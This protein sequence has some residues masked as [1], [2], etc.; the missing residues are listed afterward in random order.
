LAT[1]ARRGTGE[2]RRQFRHRSDGE[3]ANL[4]KRIR[5]SAAS[6][7]IAIRER[8]HQGFDRGSRARAEA[9]DGPEQVRPIV[10]DCGFEG[11]DVIFARIT[12]SPSG[13]ASNRVLLS[14]VLGVEAIGAIT[15]VVWLSATTRMIFSSLEVAGIVHDSSW[16]VIARAHLQTVPS[17]VGL[18]W[19]Y[20]R[21]GIESATHSAFVASVVACLLFA[22]VV[23]RLV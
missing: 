11:L 23:V 22:L 21:H 13:A 20:V 7:G 19:L 3:W 6:F 15:H 4:C 5:G 18:G 10:A 2:Q 14:A 17:A 16:L 9:S 1:N 12:V 8:S